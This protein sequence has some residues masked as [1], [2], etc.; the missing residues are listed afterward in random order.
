LTLYDLGLRNE[1][2][3]EAKDEVVEVSRIL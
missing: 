2:G 3:P 1:E